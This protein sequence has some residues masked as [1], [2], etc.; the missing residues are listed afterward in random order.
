MLSIL[1]PVYNRD[2]RPLVE[3]LMACAERWGGDYEI[4]VSDDASPSEEI[5]SLNQDLASWPSCRYIASEENHG[6]AYA[7]NFLAA[8][9]LYPYL[10]FL[11][12]DV[13]PVSDDF[14]ANYMNAAGA[15][16]SAQGEARVV[17][18]GFVY[19]RREQ[20][21]LDIRL[22]HRYGCQVEETTAKERNQT[23]YRNFISMNFLAA[24]SVFE[25]VLF[26]TSF[27]QC[28]YEDTLFGKQLQASGI[29]IGHIDNPVFHLVEEDSAAYLKKIRVSVENLLG[30][31]TEMQPYVRL[32][33]W[34]ASL[35]RMGLSR[36]T[37]RL[38]LRFENALTRHLCGPNPSLKLFAFYKLG[39]LCVLETRT[40]H[41]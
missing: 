9:A 8:Q 2:V 36:L 27:R 16:A 19:P 4:V 11:D 23:P 35:R 12:A 37:A 41:S 15:W 3:R 13:M 31:E 28:G 32:L 24:R 5:R 6:V 39:Y 20:V 33:Q 10:L 34:Y 21:P 38:F 40:A 1:I 17:C 30:H 18:G 26:D 22:R 7:R 29:T 25:R 14:I